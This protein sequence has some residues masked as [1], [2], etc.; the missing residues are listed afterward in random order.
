M[1]TEAPENLYV[2]P[3][4][5]ETLAVWNANDLDGWRYRVYLD[6]VPQPHAISASVER[7]TVTLAD[8]TREERCRE[9]GAKVRVPSM[10]YDVR[11]GRTLTKRGKVEIRRK[12]G[13]G[14]G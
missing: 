8:M 9:T 1:P 11:S 7:G 5:P 13:R 4:V 6:G 2:L 12:P 14:E 10:F 3:P